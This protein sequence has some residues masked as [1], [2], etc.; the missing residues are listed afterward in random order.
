MDLTALNYVKLNFG[1][2][3]PLDFGL[4]SWVEFG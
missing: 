2:D 4:G 1:L 3:F